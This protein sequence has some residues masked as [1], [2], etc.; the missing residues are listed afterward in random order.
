MLQAAHSV[1]RDRPFA[2]DVASSL[3]SK[4]KPGSGV[5]KFLSPPQKSRSQVHEVDDSK[6]KDGSFYDNFISAMPVCCV[7]RAPDVL[8]S[9]I[10]ANTRVATCRS[11]QNLSYVESP[12]SP[13][14]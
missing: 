11:I 5:Y 10:V 12:T 7:D 1:F 3:G 4:I 14:L 13:K 6:P 9:T 8:A 2:R